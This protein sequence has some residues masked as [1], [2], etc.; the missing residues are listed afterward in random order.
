MPDI[1]EM[2]P[3]EAKKMMTQ[4]SKEESKN[5][6]EKKSKKK[7]DVA[8]DQKE[9]V[10]KKRKTSPAPELSD[11]RRTTAAA[12]RCPRSLA[13][14]FSNVLRKM[15]MASRWEKL[16]PRRT[17]SNGAWKKPARTELKSTLLLPMMGMMMS[18]GTFPVLA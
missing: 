18:D 15:T 8:P 16:P 6:E 5:K 11:G 3:K 12:R 7:S 17:G 9:V 10:E 2:Q 4:S 1:S 13:T 14:T